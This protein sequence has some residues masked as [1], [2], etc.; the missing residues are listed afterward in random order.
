[1]VLVTLAKGWISVFTKPFHQHLSTNLLVS[2]CLLTSLSVF[3]CLST[4]LLVSVCLLT[5]LSMLVY[6]RTLQGHS[7][8]AELGLI[9]RSRQQQIIVMDSFHLLL[10]YCSPFLDSRDMPQMSGG[11]AG[12][13]GGAKKKQL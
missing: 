2:V 8:F 12:G 1:M 4:N 13:G 6:S 3:Q 5:S 7:S 10:L 11:G 9:S